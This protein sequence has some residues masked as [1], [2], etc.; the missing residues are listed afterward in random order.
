MAQRKFLM[1]GAAFPACSRCTPMTA[2]RGQHI[3]GDA[4]VLKMRTLKFV[5]WA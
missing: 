5:L 4:T 1:L 2:S 3:R